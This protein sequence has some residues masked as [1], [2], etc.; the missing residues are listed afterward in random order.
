MK[1]IKGPHP[2][3]PAQAGEGVSDRL[4]PTSRVGQRQA[5]R[6][7]E[8]DLKTFMQASPASTIALQGL[9]VP[10]G[11]HLGPSIRTTGAGSALVFR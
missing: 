11:S 3:R 7:R 10:L 5:R 4:L 9:V 8:I 6:I 2:D 1:K